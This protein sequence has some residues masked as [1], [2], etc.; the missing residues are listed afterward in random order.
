MIIRMMIMVL[1]CVSAKCRQNRAYIGPPELVVVDADGRRWTFTDA[2][3]S[4][5]RPQ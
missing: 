5:F 4:G 2:A 1:M 3:T